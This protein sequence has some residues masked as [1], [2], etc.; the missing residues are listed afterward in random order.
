[1]CVC[2]DVRFGLS[3]FKKPPS[4]EQLRMMGHEVFCQCEGWLPID[5]KYLIEGMTKV[6]RSRKS[7]RK[8][9]PTKVSGLPKKQKTNPRRSKSSSSSSRVVDLLTSDSE[10]SD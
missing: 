5:V 8:S 4:D 2:V 3:G 10:F 9:A 1:M 7:K 6:P